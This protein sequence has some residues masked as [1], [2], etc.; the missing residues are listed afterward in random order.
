M[1]YQRDEP[2]IIPVQGKPF[3]VVPY[4][5]RNNDIGRFGGN[6]AMTAAAF[7]QGLKTN[8]ICFIRKEEHRSGG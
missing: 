3:A 6:T 5:L 7:L 8:S 2:S 4:T 1:I